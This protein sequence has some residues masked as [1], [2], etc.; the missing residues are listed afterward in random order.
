[1]SLTETISPQ[2]ADYKTDLEP[3]NY[4]LDACPFGST[5]VWDS[6]TD[7]T[8]TRPCNQCGFTDCGTCLDS[9]SPFG[10]IAARRG[11]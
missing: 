5:I 9:D 4:G 10:H 11:W 2:H 8:V 3:D 6:D 7:L 1:M